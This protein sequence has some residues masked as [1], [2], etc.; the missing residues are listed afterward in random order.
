MH[1]SVYAFS[2]LWK[3]TNKQT[4]NIDAEMNMVT[5]IIYWHCTIHYSHQDLTFVSN[6]KACGWLWPLISLLN[7]NA[8]LIQYKYNRL[9][10]VHFTAV[11]ESNV[12]DGCPWAGHYRTGSN[13]TSGAEAFPHTECQIIRVC[14]ERILLDWWGAGMET[15][16]WSL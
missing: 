13:P 2:N 15:S 12:E 11:W 8:K 5:L 6:T 1:N 4:K 10:S 16:R 3:Q 14:A 7:E 9:Y